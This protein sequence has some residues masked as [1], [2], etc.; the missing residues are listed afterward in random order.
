M[1]LR[2]TQTR[3]LNYKSTLCKYFSLTHAKNIKIYRILETVVHLH[4]PLMVC[5]HEDVPLRSDVRNLLLL[6]HVCL[7]KDLH[8]IHMSSILLL[9][10]SYLYIFFCFTKQYNGCYLNG[11][12]KL[13]LNMRRIQK[14]LNVTVF[15]MS[16]RRSEIKSKKY[17]VDFNDADTDNDG[18]T[19]IIRYH[20]FRTLTFYRHIVNLHFC[21]ISAIHTL[22]CNLQYCNIE[23][24]LLQSSVLYGSLHFLYNNNF[25]SNIKLE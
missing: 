12:I 15:Q 24:I 17:K 23:A 14:Y 3:Q 10:E 21:N 8:R 9:Y 18:F 11:I 13:K 5:F 16:R 1:S 7:P 2:E 25:Y 22:H 19:P 4:D 6:E 20:C